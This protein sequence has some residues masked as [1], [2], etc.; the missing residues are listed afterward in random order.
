MPGV[1][2]ELRGLV[3]VEVAALL[4]AAFVALPVPSSVP[5]LVVASLSLYLRRTS[6]ADRM[7]GPGL[8]AAIGAVAGLVALG[9]AIAIGTPLVE[10]LTDQAVNWSMY[11]VVRGSGTTAVTVAIVVG[12][13]A[14]ASELVLRGWIVERVLE[15]GRGHAVLAILVG[16]FA[17]ALLAGGTLE[18]RIGAGV[19]GIGLGAM[20]VAGGRSVVAPICARLVFALGALVLEATRV[21]G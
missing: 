17:E 13:G 3:P 14:L 1:T 20:Y 18:A 8:H 2:R 19:F 11:P 9:V 12:V 6:W 7:R 21:V 10:G 5:L 4:A 15:L 16:A